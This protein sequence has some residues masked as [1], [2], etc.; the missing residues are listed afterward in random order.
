[1]KA[2]RKMVIEKKMMK[3]ED[4]CKPKMAIME[5]ENERK[6]KQKKMW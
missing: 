4:E 3:R 6:R 2:K 1:M 5:K